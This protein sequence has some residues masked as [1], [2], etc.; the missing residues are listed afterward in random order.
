MD[1]LDCKEKTLFAISKGLNITIEV[2][3]SLE[4]EE[5]KTLLPQFLFD[6]INDYRK[7]VRTDSTL[8]DCYSDQLNSSI[9]VTEVEHLIS[10]ETADRLRK[11][12]F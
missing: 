7:A 9:N 4:K 12:Y 11:R 3:L 10:K 5:A 1:I 8:W 6:S 2:L